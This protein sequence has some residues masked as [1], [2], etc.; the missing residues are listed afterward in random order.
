MPFLPGWLLVPSKSVQVP[1]PAPGSSNY[2]PPRSAWASPT[3]GAGQTVCR[4]PTTPHATPGY[5]NNNLDKARQQQMPFCIKTG[6]Q[7]LCNKK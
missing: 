7:C 4:W 2:E 3:Q 6:G 5:W 1:A